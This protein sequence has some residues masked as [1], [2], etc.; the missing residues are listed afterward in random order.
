MASKYI[1][2]FFPFLLLPQCSSRQRQDLD[3]GLPSLA[4]CLLWASLLE[5]TKHTSLLV[6]T[7]WNGILS[8]H[9]S[10]ILNL[11]LGLLLAKLR[12][13]WTESRRSALKCPL[14]TCRHSSIYV[15]P[16]R[17][18]QRLW[19]QSANQRR[20]APSGYPEELPQGTAAWIVYKQLISNLYDPCPLC[21]KVSDSRG[22]P[23]IGLVLRSRAHLKARGLQS[24]LTKASTRPQPVCVCLWGDGCKFLQNWQEC[25]YRRE[26]R[27]SM[28]TS[29]ACLLHGLTPIPT[30]PTQWNAPSFLI[31]FPSVC[32]RVCHVSLHFFLKKKKQKK[33]KT[34]CYKIFH[35]I[36]CS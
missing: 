7:A 5:G 22:Q 11:H 6:T 15:I 2:C 14:T 10:K 4:C 19:Q 33:R 9:P 25:Y 3:A 16:V 26:G 18:F 30:H 21:H 17:N 36:R 35:M 28:N 27:Y 24:A 31:I 23:L 20:H 1:L 13:H 34:C 29:R 12:I 32:L 8:Q